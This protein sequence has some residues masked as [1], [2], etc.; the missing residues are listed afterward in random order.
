LHRL[1]PDRWAATHHEDVL[2]HRPDESRRN[3]C[4]RDQRRAERR[5]SR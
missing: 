1:L 2:N 4:R 5:G 3:A